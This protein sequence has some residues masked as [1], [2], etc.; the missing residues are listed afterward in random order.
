MAQELSK[1]RL[2]QYHATRAQNLLKEYAEFLESIANEII[3][4][5]SVEIS[6]GSIDSVALSYARQQGARNAARLF[7]KKI[8]THANG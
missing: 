3:S 7:M 2:K 8:N 1:D 5:N 6:E 4:E